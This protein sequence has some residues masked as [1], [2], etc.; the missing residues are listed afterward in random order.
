MMMDMQRILRDPA[1]AVWWSLRKPYTFYQL[2]MLRRTALVGRHVRLYVHAEW[3][4]A[5][6]DQLEIGD[7]VILGDVIFHIH[8]HGKV[9]IGEYT[10]I[11]GVR[12]ECGTGVTIGKYCQL[13]YNVDIHD[14]NG[15]P[16]E[17]E[18]RKKQ[19]LSLH[20]KGMDPPSVYESEMAPVIIGDNVWIGHDVTIMKGVMIGDNAI[21]ATGSV[22]THHVP[23]NTLAAGNPAR[24][25]KELGEV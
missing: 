17:P 19:I 13:S 10:A 22:V 1:H 20:H 16:V 25:V 21:I 5:R 3:T 23:A 11:S 2:W 8:G 18:E 7:H 14:N 4:N 12:I 9:S 6:N 24:V 15:H